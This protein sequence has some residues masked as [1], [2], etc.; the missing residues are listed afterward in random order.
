ME[1]RRRPDM[2]DAEEDFRPVLECEPF[3]YRTEETLSLHFD[4]SVIQS[5]MRCDA[6]HELVLAY[7]QTMMGFLLFNPHPRKIFMIGLGGGSLPK[8]CYAN[9]PETSIV[10]AEINPRVIAL[11]RTFA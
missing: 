5:E 8:Y 11:R 7:T 4:I 6:P 3:V 2:S 10:V 1:S 9:L